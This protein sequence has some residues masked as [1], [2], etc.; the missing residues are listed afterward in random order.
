MLFTAFHIVTSASQ[1]V[2]LFDY[3]DGLSDGKITTICKD[4]SGLMWIGTESGLSKFDG[5]KFSEITFFENH[6]IRSVL[7]DTLKNTLWIGS[8]KGLFLYDINGGSVIDATKKINMAEVIEIVAFQN[9]KI[10]VFRNGQVMRFGL[11]GKV[12]I[13]FNVSKI[14]LREGETVLKSSAFDGMGNV[15]LLLKNNG[16]LFVVYNLISRKYGVVNKFSDLDIW[17][18]RSANGH[19][20]LNIGNTKAGFYSPLSDLTIMNVPEA[21]SDDPVRVLQESNGEYYVSY[22]DGFGSYKN[23]PDKFGWKVQDKMKLNDL[24]KSK[25]IRIFYKDKENVLWIGTSKGII[26][27]YEDKRY[28]FGRVFCE[29]GKTSSIRQ[30]VSG[31]L[32][33]LF[34]ATYQGIY[35]FNV[36]NG[37]Y[38][39]LTGASNGNDFPSYARS[40]YFDGKKYLYIG[41]ES[42][43]NYFF[44]YNTET[45]HFE[46]AFLRGVS[47]PDL[48]AVYSMMR[49]KNG[50]IWMATNI[51]LAS[52]D[53]RKNLFKVHNNDRYSVGAKQL[54]Y[55][56]MTHS[57]DKFLVCGK[58][59]AFLI[60]I[61]K[62]VQVSYNASSHKE[63]SE[64]DYLFAAEDQNK[65]VW[66]GTK[67]HGVIVF[68]LNGEEADLINKSNGLAS[69]EVYSILWQGADIA[70]MSTVN[71][72]S[73]YDMEH[74]S[75]Q[76][77]S[78]E[79]GIA[80]DEFNQHSFYKVS[81]TLMY[82]GG[83]NGLTFFNPQYF[84]TEQNG[85]NIFGANITRWDERNKDNKIT[86][87]DKV[88]VMN[89]ADY[90][91]T[92][93]FGLND[94]RRTEDNT[95]YY[96]I[97]GINKDWINLGPEHSI[98]LNGLAP[99]MHQI[100]IKGVS[101]MGQESTNTLEL[102]L[103]VK[104]YIYKTVWFYVLLAMGLI[105]I[106]YSY[107]RWRLNRLTQQQLLRAEISNNLHD[108]V[109]SLMTQV[110]ISTE[111]ALYTSD[112]TEDKNRYLSLIASLSRD[113]IN[114]MSDVL[115]G[116]D[117]WNDFV[118]NLTD[119]MREHAEI[120]FANKE[121]EVEFEFSDAH[122]SQKMDS[123][124]RQH[125]YL[126]FKEA[127]HNIVKHSNADSVKV[128][129]KQT[130]SKFELLVA[131][132]NH[133]RVLQKTKVEGQG[134]RNID[135]RAK[136]IKAICTIEVLSDWY[137]LHLKSMQLN[138]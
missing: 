35:D 4:G 60:D 78:S 8:N 19:C 71:G 27:I 84:H 42:T 137:T 61:V 20:L 120:M 117:S 90:L 63:T 73:R 126:I 44:R 22:K 101:G 48:Y 98:T 16:T 53:T 108:E 34:V 37:E 82:F 105:I 87:N 89:P 79:N 138:K 97:N 115:W 9:Q 80:D 32:G 59:G 93:N 58:G 124:V 74:R 31:R 67:N 83:I 29:A 15:Y 91:I 23:L 109:G 85:V 50:I 131:N 1:N 41:T 21:Q 56:T 92:V 127:I 104:Q 38:T 88:I 110:I 125:V 113:A 86:F 135:V 136:K 132:N 133:A 75:F 33:R 66:F 28:P 128:M 65:Q 30:I 112:S 116:I 54:M 39:P 134:L 3:A 76:N 123:Q 70:W 69:N 72:L 121:I 57:S 55:I 118:G 111:H 47:N 17:Y 52:F 26:K 5:Y 130:G 11:S 68:K 81:D 13:V 107:F 6:Y 94:Y 129:Y 36:K 51:G 40:L 62:G 49:D 7:Y 25:I 64:V 2:Q 46:G 77:Y 14:G 99:G 95:F 122:I 102:T 106:L 114:T 100:L 103:Q 43:Q 12:E 45:K 10:V 18:I 24:L 96:R 119:R